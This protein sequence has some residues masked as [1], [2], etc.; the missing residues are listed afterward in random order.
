MVKHVV[1]EFVIGERIESVRIPVDRPVTAQFFGAQ[2][3]NALVFQLEVFDYCEGCVCFSEADAV[4][5]NA[6]IQ[7]ADLI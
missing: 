4:S 2:H 1:T 7:V 5:E 3:E 6:T